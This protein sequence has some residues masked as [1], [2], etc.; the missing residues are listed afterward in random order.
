MEIFLHYFLLFF[1]YSILGWIIEVIACGI[2]EK[3]FVMRG[4]LIGPYCPIYGWSAL[5][6][7]ILLRRYINDPIAFF[8]MSMLIATTIEYFGSY[9]MEKVFKVRWWDYSEKK[10]NIN[11]RVCLENAVLFGLLGLILIYGIHPF[12]DK[13]IEMFPNEAT[14]NIS[15]LLFIIYLIDNIISFSIISN[16]KI[17]IDNVHKDYTEIIDKKIWET[18]SNQSFYNKRL[19]SAFPNFKISKR[20]IKK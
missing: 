12:V 6:M 7:I 20:K 16:I 13:F 10:F 4:F 14:V 8:V 18:I 1:I 9:L 19:L 5:A 15:I 2:N 11:G 3:K 17:S